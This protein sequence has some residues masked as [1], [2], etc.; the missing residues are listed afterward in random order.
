MVRI[1]DR[2]K[3]QKKTHYLAVVGR[4]AFLSGWGQAKKG[5]S[6]AA[7]AIAP[8]IDVNRIEQWVRSR[9]DMKHVY[10]VDLRTY[11]PP[12]NTVHFHIYVCNEDHPAAQECS[13]C[14]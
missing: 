11:H 4:D 8:G 6:R 14:R 12:S 9:G 3:E 5:F 7:W 2:T 10:L 1:D 13:Y